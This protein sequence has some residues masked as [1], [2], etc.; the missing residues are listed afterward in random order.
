LID[1]FQLAPSQ[2]AK[3]KMEPALHSREG[4]ADLN[5]ECFRVENVAVMTQERVIVQTDDAGRVSM[6]G[7]SRNVDDDRKRNPLQVVLVD[8]NHN[9][10]MRVSTAP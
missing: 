10:L 3:P 6:T 9:P 4:C 1:E 5:R 8:G 2:E 7:Q